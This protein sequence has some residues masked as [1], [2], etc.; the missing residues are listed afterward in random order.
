MVNRYRRPADYK[1]TFGFVD[2][3]CAKSLSTF[4]YYFGDPTQAAISLMTSRGTLPGKK[5][6]SPVEGFSDAIKR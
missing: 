5:Y 3:E 1:P 6:S 4:E 2:I